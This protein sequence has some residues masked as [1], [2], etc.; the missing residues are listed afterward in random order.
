[1]NITIYSTSICPACQTLTKWLDKVGQMYDK[2]VTDTDD[3]LMAE[4]MEVNDGMIGVPFSV[5]RDDA[6]EIV[7][8]IP[9]YDQA[10]FKTI[11]GL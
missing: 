7:A 6:G 1:M 5:I 10:K 2:K 8:K 4:F 9:G 11:L 3:A